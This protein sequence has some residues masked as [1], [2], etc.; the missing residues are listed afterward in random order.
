MKLT[1]SLLLLALVTAAPSLAREPQ[2]APLS[3][4]FAIRALG[5]GAGFSVDLPIVARARG[6]STTFFTSLDITNNTA[7]P[8]GVDFF[9]TPAD[10]SATRSGSFGTLLGFDNIHTEDVVLSLADAGILPPGQASN[11]FGTML[12]TFD[13]PGFRT[14]NEATAVARVWSHA[15]GSSGPTNGTAYRAQ[16]LRTHGAHA[17]SGLVRNGEGLLSSLG[18]ENVGIDDA[19]QA[20]E[21]PLTVRLTFVDPRSGAPVGAQPTFVLGPGQVTQVS[22]LFDVDGRNAYR[23]P[24][25]AP[26]LLVFAE[27]VS[28]TSQLSGYVIWKDVNTND[29]AFVLMQEATA[30]F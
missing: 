1:P 7:E 13:N 11:T 9:Y 4:P 27:A 25:D 8:T 28:G 15:A 2:V 29:G 21:A 23:L 3:R 18:I 20:V 26:S 30:P 14:G 16:P 6:F 24:A 17:L 19:G 12:L 22:G 10:G 5:Q